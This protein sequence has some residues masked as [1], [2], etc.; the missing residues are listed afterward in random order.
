MWNNNNN[1]SFLLDS[2]MLY[3]SFE[4]TNILFEKSNCAIHFPTCATVLALIVC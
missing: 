4:E 3:L 2:Y 1:D